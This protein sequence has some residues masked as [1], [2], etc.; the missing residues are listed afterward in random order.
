MLAPFST[1]S[2]PISTPKALRLVAMQTA[3]V[4]NITAPDDQVMR[5]A[6]RFG[7][8]IHWRLSVRTGGRCRF[9]G[10]AR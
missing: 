8:R 4:T 2:M 3:P 10:R 1:S 5:H 6:D 7:Q 9:L